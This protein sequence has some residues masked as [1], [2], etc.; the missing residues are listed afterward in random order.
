MED[1]SSQFLILVPVVVGLTQ[2]IKAT[3]VDTRW[4]PLVAVALGIIG[5]IIFA[6]LSW[7]AVIGGI[8][9]GL[10]AAGLFSGVKKTVG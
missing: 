6:G 10:T 7:G 2:A 8:V 5:A 9:A 1:V 4:S 3:G